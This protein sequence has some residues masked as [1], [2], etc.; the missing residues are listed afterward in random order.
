VNEDGT[1][2]V[3]RLSSLETL[4]RMKIAESAD[5]GTYEPVTKQVV[6]TL[7]DSREIVFLNAETAAPLGKLKM[8]SAKMEFPTPDGRGHLYFAQRD[9]DMVS[10][11]DARERKVVAEWKTE[12]CMEPNGLALDRASKRLF[13]GCRGK[14]KDPVFIVMDA[15]SGKV[16]TTLDL[17]RGND[18]VVYDPETH[19][20]YASNGVDGNLV[21][22]QQV[23]ADTYQLAEAPTTRPFARTMALDPKTNKV[24]LVTAE[25]TVDPAKKINKGPSALY[26]NRYFADTFMLL[27]LSPN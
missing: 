25:G 1:T 8:Q 4:K 20:I 10:R 9:R 2:T 16:I 21:I 15:E 5:S 14:G 27:T 23:D 3:F 6:V 11:V 13:I 17:G 26:P 18:G 24:Y 12:G 22:I 7:N 19:K